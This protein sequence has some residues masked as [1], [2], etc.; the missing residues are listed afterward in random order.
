MDAYIVKDLLHYCNVTL[1]STPHIEK[2]ATSY[3]DL[4]FVLKG[5][6][7]FS[8]DGEYYTVRENDAILIRPGSLRERLFS[9]GAVKYISYNFTVFNDRFL[10]KR[11]FYENI[12][13]HDIRSLFSIFSAAHISSVY[14][15]REKAANLLNYIL[16][17]IK[18]I[19]EFETNNKHVISIIKHIDEHISEPITLSTVSDRV[20]L[21]KEYT[22]HIFKKE[23]GKT[24]T[25]YINERKLFFARK[26]ILETKYPL[27]YVSERVGYENYSYFSKLFKK[28][29][30]ISPLKLKSTKY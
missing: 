6:M 15:S 12:I 28:R 5:E 16:L 2:A 8:V 20:K 14:S 1:K 18:D 11:L 22:S 4:T 13:S 19:L 7:T 24:V 27:T 25:E 9:D 26:M 21:S 10:P 30:G 17:E 3:Y 23:T 29:F